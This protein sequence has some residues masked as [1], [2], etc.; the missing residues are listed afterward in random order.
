[1]ANDQAIAYQKEMFTRTTFKTS[2]REEF[3]E[4]KSELIDLLEQMLEYNP[5]YRPTAK[6]LLKSKLF[7]DIRVPE[8]QGIAPFKIVI[9]IDNNEWQQTYTKND[10]EATQFTELQKVEHFQKMMAIEALNFL[11]P[12]REKKPP[13]NLESNSLSTK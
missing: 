2:I 3:K 9:K 7:D 11:M 13:S 1:M 10:I 8:M 4:T 12:N 6:Q 5:Y